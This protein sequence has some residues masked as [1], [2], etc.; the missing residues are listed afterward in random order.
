MDQFST[1][2]QLKKWP[3]FLYYD[4]SE[5]LW[6][7][8]GVIKLID[9]IHIIKLIEGGMS[10]RAVSRKTGVDRETVTRYYNEY[11]KLEEQ[12]NL[13]TSKIEIRDLQNEIISKPKYS[14][15]KEVKIKWNSEMDDFLDYHLEREEDRNIKFGL[16][17]KQHTTIVMMHELLLQAGHD[18]GLTTVRN[19]MAEKREKLKEVF[20]RQIYNPGQRFEFDFGEVYLIIKNIKCKYYLAVMSSPYSNF[21]T[22]IFIIIKVKKFF[23]MHTIDFSKR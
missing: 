23:L 16:N 6:R 17:H 15:R 21:R 1:D 13:S 3:L 9:K 14:K 4:H 8:I 7:T 18:I 10:L 12:L 20:V 5:N 19:K 22:A 2:Y 11:Q